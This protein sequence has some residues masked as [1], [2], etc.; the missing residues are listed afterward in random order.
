MSDKH[1]NIVPEVPDFS[2]DESVGSQRDKRDS[3]PNPTVVILERSGQP[4]AQD[5]PNPQP[6]YLDSDVLAKYPVVMDSGDLIIR[7]RKS[8][9]KN[10][11]R[12]IG[13]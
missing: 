8:R 5:K 6:T 13:Y 11:K 9:S 2:P 4:Q 1:I 12:I 7:R 10:R 3:Q